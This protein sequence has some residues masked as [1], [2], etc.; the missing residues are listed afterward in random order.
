MR[1]VNRQKTD[2]LFWSL[3]TPDLLEIDLR[4]DSLKMM[5]Q[6]GCLISEG[7]YFQFGPILQCP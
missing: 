2:Q 1:Y 3:E 6:K 5:E 7:T 4:F